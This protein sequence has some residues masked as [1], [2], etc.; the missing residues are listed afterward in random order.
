MEPMYTVVANM[1]EYMGCLGSRVA[2]R[3]GTTARQ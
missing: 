3:G 1:R 2:Y